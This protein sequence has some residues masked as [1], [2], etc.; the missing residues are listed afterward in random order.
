MQNKMKKNGIL[1]SFL[2]NSE[3]RIWRHLLFIAIGT[4]IVFNQTFVAYA[5]CLG[6]LGDRIYL[7]CL[8]SFIIYAIAVYVNYYVLVPAF[9]LKNRYV[10]YSI[11]LSIVVFLL[12]TLSVAEEYWVRNTL[13]IPHRI[14]SYT[15]PLILVDNLAT[16]MI[17]VICLCGMAAIR[18][19]RYREAEDEQV[20]RLEH[21][22][23]KS[24]VNKLK[25]QITPG[26]LSETLNN[27]AASAKANPSK[28]S[29]MLMRLGQLL[30]YQLY[31]CNR[32]RVFFKSEI[33]FLTGFLELEQ[34]NKNR[35]QYNIHIDGNLNNVFVSPMLFISLIQSRIET[36]GF[37]N[38]FFKVDRKI[39]SFRCESDVVFDSNDETMRAAKNSLNLQYPG[40]Y[41]LSL[42]SGIIDLQIDIAE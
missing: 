28:T 40:K 39:L 13:N 17:T 30:R 16:C 4:V 35:F 14:T 18:L 26:F 2:V 32:D 1:P 21:E 38:L 29:N 15:N 25:G 33:D 36:A 27:A 12:P 10:A 42:S 8:S 37:L 19:F 7:I 5:D 6:I 41:E 20:N 11:M 34:L 31:D 3:Y 24:E 23:L 9:L 22:H